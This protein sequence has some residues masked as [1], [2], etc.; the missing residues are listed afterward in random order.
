M[1]VTRR[2][3]LTGAGASAVVGS[4]SLLS[5]GSAEAATAP[6]LKT[7]SS[8]AW[9]SALQSRLSALGYWLGAVDGQFGGLTQQAVI[10][11]QKVAGVSRDGVCGPVTWSKVNAGVRPRGASRS[12]HV[13]EIDKSRQVLLH[14]DSGRVRQILSTSTGSG[15]RYYSRGSW[16]TASTPSGRYRVFRSVNGWDYGPLGGLYRPRYFDGGIAVHGYGYVPAY[17]ASHGCCRVSLQAMDMVWS[18][19]TMPIG[20][21]V[22]VY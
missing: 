9:T 19:D 1:Q 16:H 17:P 2:T 6:V 4:L 18:A 14:V 7:G 10:A 12:G 13:I 8:G 22:W 3:A 11:I 21:P 15:Q 20:S 5:A